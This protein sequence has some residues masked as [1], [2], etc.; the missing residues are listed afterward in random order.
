P[1]G[2]I[3]SAFQPHDGP[4][5]RS[6]QAFLA[7]GPE[8]RA[9]EGGRK[10]EPQIERLVRAS[11]AEDSLVLELID[12]AVRPRLGVPHRGGTERRASESARIHAMA[13]C[14]RTVER[15][16]SVR[17]RP[18]AHRSTR[19]ASRGDFWSSHS[20]A[21]S[22]AAVSPVVPEVSSAEASTKALSESANWRSD[23]R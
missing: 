11:H 7:G 8:H 14:K 17:T 16:G 18:R 5:K 20:R 13:S 21:R 3:V 12:A 15:R 23:R 1:R 2:G 22:H 10:P 4:E 6:A 9:G 19:A